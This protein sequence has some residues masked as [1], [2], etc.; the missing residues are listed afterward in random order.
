MNTFKCQMHSV[1]TMQEGRIQP[2]SLPLRRRLRLTLARRMNPHL[3]RFIKNA[4]RRFSRWGS[5]RNHTI[6]TIPEKEVKPT[7]ERLKSGDVVRIRSLSEIR[8]TLD[9]EG[10]LKGCRFMPEMEQYCGSVQRVFKPLE[11]FLNEFDYTIRQSNGM[12]L[13]ENLFCQGVVEAGRCDRS[14]FFFWRMEWLEKMEGN[15]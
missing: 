8:A 4:L 12:V 15:L 11:R 9:S 10:R 14:C 2:V 1:D 6:G 13:L 5:R 7:N 3:K